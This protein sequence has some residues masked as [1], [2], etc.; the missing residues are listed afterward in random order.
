MNCIA[1]PAKPAHSHRLSHSFIPHSP[2]LSL[3]SSEEQYERKKGEEKEE[4]GK[5][6]K[7]KIK[8]CS[9]ITISRRRWRS[10]PPSLFL[11]EIKKSPFHFLEIISQTINLD[12]SMHVCKMKISSYSIISSVSSIMPYLT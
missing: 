3:S 6:K 4:K 7:K 12:F 5:K 9:C 8:E 11:G 1:R 2:S 10:S